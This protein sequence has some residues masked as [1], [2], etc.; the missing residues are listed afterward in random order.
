MTYNCLKFAQVSGL[1]EE[2]AETWGLGVHRVALS[3]PGRGL[4]ANEVAS[5]LLSTPRWGLEPQQPAATRLPTELSAL[6]SSS[7]GN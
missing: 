3:R 4:R 7:H 6:L 5:S 2:G 1:S